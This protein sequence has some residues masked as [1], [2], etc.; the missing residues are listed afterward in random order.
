MK[1]FKR[2]K[3]NFVC[4]H[5][6]EKVIG[7]GYTDHCPKCLWAKHVDGDIPGDRASDCRGMMEPVGAEFQISNVQFLIKY[8][9]TKCR[10]QFRVRG[11]KGD[12]RELLMKLVI[13]NT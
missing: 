1:N 3:E 8:K 12:D 5:C 2:V 10:H 11:G 13:E 7:D 4:E 6:G 9:C